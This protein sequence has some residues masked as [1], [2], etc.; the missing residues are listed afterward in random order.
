MAEAKKETIEMFGTGNFIVGDRL[1]AF[2]DGSSVEV[3]K[4]EDIP[5]LEAESKRRKNLAIKL[6][7]IE[8]KKEIGKA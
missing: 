8:V 2:R 3:Q 1:Y 6:G 7:L 4:K 5:F